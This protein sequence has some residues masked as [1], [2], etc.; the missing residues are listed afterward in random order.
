MLLN[1]ARL[2]ASTVQGVSAVVAAFLERALPCFGRRELR[3]HA[4]HVLRGK[5][6]TWNRKTCEPIA[7]EAGVARK[8][9]L[10]RQ[11]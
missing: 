7:R 9:I 8:P 4:L 3:D 5:L 10:T 6:S 11:R 1:D 2:S